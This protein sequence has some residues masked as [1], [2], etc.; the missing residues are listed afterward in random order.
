[1][2]W[3]QGDEPAGVSGNRGHRRR[4]PPKSRSVFPVQ[5]VIRPNQD[6]RGYAGQIASG[7][8]AAGR[9]RVRAAFGPARRIKAIATFD[10]DLDAAYS[11][12]SVTL[13][14]ED[15]LDM[16]RGDMLAEADGPPGAAAHFEARL[17]WINE[18]PLDVS[19]RYLLKHTTQLVSA[20]VS[21]PVRMDIHTLQSEPAATLEMN[22]IGTVELETSKPLFFDS[23]ERNRITGSLVLIDLDTNATVAAGMIVQAVAGH[24]ARPTGPV[25]A[26]E[27]RARFGHG[28]AAVFVGNREALAALLERR[29]FDRGCA[30]VAL[31][32]A[33]EDGLRAL[34]AAGVIAIAIGN[35]EQALPEN[36]AQAAEEI[37]ERL[38]AEKWEKGGGI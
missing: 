35:A 16:S 8:G 5:R 26:A 12:M 27:R 37:I 10:G 23:Y 9:F 38:F 36:D 28:P 25:T 6:F 17:V 31:R 20:R 4:R 11:P 18:R 29:L 14:L 7:V 15:E 21:G 2:P 32:E 34:Q 22:E 33:T 24:P 3:F 13:T 19:R 1:M 30:V